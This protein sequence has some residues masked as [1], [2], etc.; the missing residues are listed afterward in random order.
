M[1]KKA[2][3]LGILAAIVVISLLVIG[4]LV[5]SYTEVGMANTIGTRDSHLAE[6]DYSAIP[7]SVL[8]DAKEIAREIVGNSHDKI[9]DFVDQLLATYVEAK[10]S[11]IVVIPRPEGIRHG[12]KWGMDATMPINDREWQ[13]K[14]CVPGVDEVDYIES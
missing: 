13:S 2:G 6:Y 9:Q 12:K 10:E 3:R 11:D 8:E 7:P 14:A 1:L 4:W 5:F